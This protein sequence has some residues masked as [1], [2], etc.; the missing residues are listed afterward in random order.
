MADN[1]SK[2]R[3]PLRDILFDLRMIIGSLFAVYGV[4]CLVCGAFFYTKADSHRSGGI[5]VNLWAGAGMLVAAALFVAW[6]LWRPL[7]EAEKD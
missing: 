2:Q 7:V 4:V 3:P 1:D 5:N 6:T